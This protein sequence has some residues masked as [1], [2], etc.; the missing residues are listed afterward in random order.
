MEKDGDEVIA[1]F[2]SELNLSHGLLDIAGPKPLT[3]IIAKAR[4]GYENVVLWIGTVHDPSK[5]G[6]I[7]AKLDRL[8]E[9]LSR[10]SSEVQSAKGVAVKAGP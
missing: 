10:C 4:L 8:R 7:T 9:R 2:E 1:F 5:L 6:R 3:E